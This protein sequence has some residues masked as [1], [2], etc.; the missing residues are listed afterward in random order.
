MKQRGVPAGLLHQ[1]PGGDALAGRIVPHDEDRLLK[2]TLVRGIHHHDPSG[3]AFHHPLYAS[4]L[5]QNL[6]GSILSQR[7]KI[8]TASHTFFTPLSRLRYST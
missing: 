1:L 6:D 5:S 4:C 7:G 2:K 3:N 8:Y